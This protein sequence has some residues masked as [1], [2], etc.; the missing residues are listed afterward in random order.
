MEYITIRLIVLQVQRER[1]LRQLQFAPQ[2]EGRGIPAA[3]SASQGRVQSQGSVL[4]AGTREVPVVAVG[5]R[6]L[7]RRRRA[8]RAQPGTRRISPV[9]IVDRPYQLSQ[10]K[11]GTVHQAPD[12][13]G[14]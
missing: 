7:S 6:V 1:W 8:G 13:K 9:K 12:K 11:A 2:R 10:G 3:N 14:A 5:A 4:R